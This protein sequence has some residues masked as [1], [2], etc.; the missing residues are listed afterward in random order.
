MAVIVA[1]GAATVAAF[2]DD[3]DSPG[4]EPETW[5][6][7][8]P[9]DDAPH[10]LHIALGSN[11][12][13]DEQLFTD[14]QYFLPAWSP[15]GEGLAAIAF[16]PGGQVSLV[17]FRRRDWS[18]RSVE[19]RDAIVAHIAWAPDGRRLALVGTTI[20]IYDLALRVD[21]VLPPVPPGSGRTTWQA[22]WSPD[23]G[24]VAIVGNGSI[25]VADADGN[26]LQ[27]VE[28]P[29]P[30]FY[31]GVGLTG[32][33]ATIEWDGNYG[34]TVVVGIEGPR[35][36]EWERWTFRRQVGGWKLHQRRPGLDIPTGTIPGK[37]DAYGFYKGR[38]ADGSA[39]VFTTFRFGGGRLTSEV[40]TVGAGAA[41]FHVDSTGGGPS[42][43]TWF[44]AVVVRE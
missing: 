2:L 43:D 17:L 40:W 37:P 20:T 8:V 33:R 10:S 4:S 5:L 28:V 44:D 14:L 24:R 16:E 25:A 27:A 9:Q 34:F 35:H 12:T 39:R 32:G 38:T 13:A 41:H 19:L 26:T 3:G 18:R 36:I 30:G 15:D 23:G 1:L 6:A 11:P 42:D 22:A 7:W 31:T 21:S 29:V